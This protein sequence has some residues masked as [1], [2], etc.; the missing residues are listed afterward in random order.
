MF[1]PHGIMLYTKEL[2][3]TDKLPKQY[4]TILETISSF[5]GNH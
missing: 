2:I 4:I 5:V 3:V 1:F